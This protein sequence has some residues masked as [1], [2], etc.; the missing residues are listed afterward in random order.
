MFRFQGSAHFD[1][2]PIS[3]CLPL[4]RQWKLHWSYNLLSFYLL[5]DK[6]ILNYYHA[7]GKKVRSKL[8]EGT[9]DYLGPVVYKNGKIDFVNTPEGRVLRPGTI[10]QDRTY[11]LHGPDTTNLFWRYEYHLNDNLGN[12]R[13]ACRCAEKAQEKQEDR[14]DGYPPYIVQQVIYDGWGVK[15]PIFNPDKYKGRPEHRFKYNGKEYMSDVGWYEY[16]FRIYD[17]SIA[18]FN[19]VDPL[20]MDYS[21]KSTFDYAE[22][23]P[24]ANIDMDGLE[25]WRSVGNKEIHGPLSRN[26]VSANSLVP[27]EENN[28][29]SIISKLKVFSGGVGTL[30]LNSRNLILNSALKSY[31][32]GS[33]GVV[34]KSTF[35][36]NQYRKSTSLP[37]LANTL[38]VISTAADYT[39][40]G[41]D[42]VQLGAAT[43]EEGFSDYV[44]GET[45]EALGNLGQ[46]TILTIVSTKLP[47]VGGNIGALSLYA[48]TPQ[49]K[50]A[51]EQG[52]VD[53]Y[54]KADYYDRLTMPRPSSL[55]PL[56]TEIYQN[57]GN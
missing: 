27:K 1:K 29:K 19:Q 42:A 20:A 41:L 40:I 34:R 56:R 31:S 37:K 23:E 4:C 21:Y 7:G 25:S 39:A 54:K 35:Y 8:P 44:G 55:G 14:Y 13:V 53:A 11:G 48:E 33:D 18:R 36:G 45:G 46:S 28:G 3:F 50:Q 38:N 47:V 24:L 16:G 15:L 32:F 22:N 49:G 5:P 6:G 2:P 12:L 26:F 30:T 10:K 17:P 9:F 43:Y 57:Y 51:V 52:K